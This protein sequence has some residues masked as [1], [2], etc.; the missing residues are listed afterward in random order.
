[1]VNLA[2]GN[3]VSGMYIA[4]TLAQIED[5]S[6]WR[7]KADEFGRSYRSFKA[8]LR[9]LAKHIWETHGV[10]ASEGNYERL[11]S[12]YR[13][14]VQTMGY[15]I[16]DA[17]LVGVSNLDLLRTLYDWDYK[18]RRLGD[19]DERKLGAQEAREHFQEIVRQS[20]ENGTIPLEV[21]KTE[22]DERL[23]REPISVKLVFRRVE[24]ED[25]ACFYLTDLQLWRG[26]TVYRPKEGIPEELKNWLAKRTRASVQEVEF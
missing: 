11:L 9:D 23:G 6:A 12:H 26:G 2:V 4:E 5:S 8:Y 10:K 16:K 17:L 3:E 19:G 24:G 1:M 20:R 14:F 22:L 21:L 15:S 7:A 13:L 18:N 25:E